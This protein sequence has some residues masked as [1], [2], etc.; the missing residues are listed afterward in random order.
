MGLGH[1]KSGVLCI[2]G[3]GIADDWLEVETQG[4]STH[5]GLFYSISLSFL[6][7]R[8]HWPPCRTL[9]LESPHPSTGLKA[10]PGPRTPWGL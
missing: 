6:F 2:V 1:T 3:P 7:P 10:W 4:H 5:L 9:I 8:S